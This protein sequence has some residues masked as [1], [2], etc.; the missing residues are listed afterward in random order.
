M[1]SGFLRPQ[2]YF[3]LT[4]WNWSAIGDR[5]FRCPDRQE[6][7]ERDDPSGTFIKTLRNS[8]FSKIGIFTRHEGDALTNI[9]NRTIWIHDS[10][11]TQNG[12]VTK[13]GSQ[14]NLR[15]VIAHELGHA[16]SGNIDCAVAS[17][18]GANTP[19]LTAAEKQ[20]LLDDAMHIMT[21]KP[22]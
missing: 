11:L 12:L 2:R 1:R 6:R 16:E 4:R 20:G 15:Q 5:A 9:P 13:R 21:R 10:V 22:E 7:A 8:I 3:N 19:K 18:T 14:L 17:R